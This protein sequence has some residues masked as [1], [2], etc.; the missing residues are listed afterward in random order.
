MTKMMK[1]LIVLMLMTM[2]ACAAP[3]IQVVDS[4]SVT[5]PKF[6][7]WARSPSMGME[8]E[9]HIGRYV[10]AKEGNEE[11]VLKHPLEL[12][13]VKMM[14]YEF[15][16][17]TKQV[18][19]HIAI[20]NPNKARYSIWENYVIDYGDG[21]GLYYIQH[22]IYDG[23]LSLKSFSHPA[24]FKDGLKVVRMKIELRDPNDNNFEVLNFGEISYTVSAK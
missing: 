18:I 6:S 3:Q 10:V 20:R 24:P 22:P 21:K 19:W 4:S 17:E 5:L 8:I 12:S 1:I 16:P 2:T 13:Q 15:G 9:Y 14:N 11:Y 23:S 7:Y